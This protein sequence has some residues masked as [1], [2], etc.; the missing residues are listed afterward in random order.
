MTTTPLRRAR[1][2]RPILSLIWRRLAQGVLTLTVV[3]VLVFWATQ[4]L[5]GNAAN[6][7][8]GK[9]ATPETLR[10][11]QA[12]LGLDKPVLEQYL[13]WLLHLITGR[14]GNSLVSSEPVVALT[15]DRLLN[16]AALV[17]VA[18]VLGTIIGVAAG[19]YAGARRDRVFD[20]VSSATALAVSAL[21]EFVVAVA[22]ILTF[23]TSVMHVLPAASPIDPGSAPW[24]QPTLLVLP[25]ATLVLVVVPYIFRMVRAVTI[26]NLG[27]DYVQTARLKGMGERDVLFRHVLPNVVPAAVQAVGLSLLYL[28]GGVVVVE[29]VFNYPG[30]GQGLVSSVAT[31]DIPVIQFLVMVL[32]LFYVV[33]NIVSDVITLVATPRRR[34]SHGRS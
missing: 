31:R 9:N 3:S 21:P 34:Y 8:L 25:I 10:A 13:S 20:H 16:S 11:L 15:S 28:A 17:L 14:P 23:S 19:M 32:A 12:Q 22:L 24:D 1:T 4:L 29:V 30:I 7:V 18:G 6:A 5:P 33:I 2:N 26:E 27:S